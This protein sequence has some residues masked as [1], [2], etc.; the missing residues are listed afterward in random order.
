MEVLPNAVMSQ[1]TELT[2]KN[3]VEIYEGDILE[4]IGNVS[5]RT[6]VIYWNN[7]DCRFVSKNSFNLHG[8]G[9]PISN[10]SINISDSTGWVVCGNIYENSEL[11]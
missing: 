1:W 5:F 11:L 7:H 9:S 3:G 4:R 2:D 8:R 10:D 6:I